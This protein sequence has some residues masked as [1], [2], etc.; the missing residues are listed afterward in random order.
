M[1][2]GS[3]WKSAAPLC[4]DYIH[5]QRELAGKFEGQFECLKH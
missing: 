1:P 3:T 2:L 4:M 5:H